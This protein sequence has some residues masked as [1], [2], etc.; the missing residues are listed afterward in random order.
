MKG[1]LLLALVLTCAACSQEDAPAG[2][3]VEAA[4]EI[5]APAAE[6]APLAKGKW[7]P[8]DTCGA[9][10]GAGAFRQRLAAAVEAR[11]ADALIALAA[12]DIKL[13]FGGG[14]GTAELRA[15]LADEGREL[16]NELDALMALG[17]SANEQGGITIPW[18]FDQ[19][20]GEAD[21][22]AA[23]LVIGED[24]PVLTAPRPT[25]ERLDAISWDLVEAA[26]FNPELPFQEIKMAGGRT[27]FIA[28]DKLRSL[29][30][31]RLMAS[32]RNGR[33]WI[34]AFVAGD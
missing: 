9:V 16:W 3:I 12:D 10:D 11:D 33:W 13:D 29:I 4:E 5:V 20:L 31:Y 32:N 18:Y 14:E 1:P 24:V 28:T 17:C 27:G 8:R 23:M 21:P 25:A 19:D 15:R 30:D 7:A 34:T 22:Y 6:P 2:E 26:S